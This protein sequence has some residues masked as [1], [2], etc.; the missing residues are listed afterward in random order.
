LQVPDQ[1]ERSLGGECLERGHGPGDLGEVSDPAAVGMVEDRD[2]AVCGHRESGLDLHA[3]RAVLGPADLGQGKAPVGMV[4]RAVQADRGHVRMQAGDIHTKGRDRRCAYRADDVV[5]FQGDRLQGSTTPVVA[6]EARG[7]AEDLL[8]CPFPGPL[9]WTSG[10]GE[11]SRFATKISIT[12]PWVRGA[13]SRTGQ[14]RSTI[15]ARSS[16]R[17]NSAITGNA[18][19]AFSTL[20]GP[21]RACCCVRVTVILQATNSLIDGHLT[22]P[23]R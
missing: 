16:R 6:Q 21:H 14:V 17:Q 20:G 18:P 23:A 13:T 11:V 1:Q 3:E 8:N 5:Q 19:R 22:A 2:A 9:L 12:W 7:D 15:P 10:D 4:E